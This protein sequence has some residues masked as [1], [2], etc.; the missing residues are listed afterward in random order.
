MKA[1][2]FAYCICLL[3]T[4]LSLN[5]AA[6]NK[7]LPRAKLQ[8]ILNQS[9]NNTSIFGV[10]AAVNNGKDYW[11]GTAGS[12]IPK[13]PYFIASTT[14]LY[15]TAIIF[16]LKAEGRLQLSDPISNY[17]PET[18]LNGLHIYKGVD[19]SRE[20]TI[21]HLLAHTSG[22]P[23]YFQ[24]KQLNGKSIL[25]ELNQGID[26]AWTFEEAIAISKTMKPHFKPGTKKKAAYSDT[27]FQ[28]LGK[29]IMNLSNDKLSTILKERIFIP[30]GLSKT[31]LYSDPTDQG[32]TLM[33][34]GNSPLNIPKA[35]SSFGADGG[36]VSTAEESAIFLKAFINGTLFPQS[37]FEYMQKDW[38]AIFFPLQYGTG[39]M[40]FKLPWYFSPFKTMPTLIGHS[41][42]SGAFCFYC[43]EK[44]I[45]LTGTVNQI[46]KPEN[47]YKL[48]L[49]LIQSID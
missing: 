29:I 9:I 10:V 43:P 16:Q 44:N 21:E 17:L 11:V 4:F 42:L 34:C 14:K 5:G 47:S 3:I 15:I 46:K 33:Y 2:L 26:Q 13:T 37:D 40:K 25:S 7:K 20:I 38:N 49:K 8:N 35:M 19:Y 18:I 48:M 31:Y 39:I 30:L 27:N 41:G 23:D 32:V 28:L 12:F 36:I 6:Q 1:K 45:F 22:L 24:G